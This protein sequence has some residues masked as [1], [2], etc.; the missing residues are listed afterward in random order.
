MNGQLHVVSVEAQRKWAI[1]KF[2]V[3]TWL[4]PCGS[5]AVLQAARSGDVLLFLQAVVCMCTFR[6][7]VKIHTLFWGGQATLQTSKQ[8]TQGNAPKAG[9]SMLMRLLDMNP[10]KGA[11]LGDYPCF[12]PHTTGLWGTLYAKVVFFLLGWSTWE[13]VAQHSMA[14]QGRQLDYVPQR[15]LSNARGQS[16]VSLLENVARVHFR[17][18]EH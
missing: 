12:H 10:S 6:P 16:S 17:H 15:S 3:P 2:S 13:G 11:S 5:F 9:N 8:L 14:M 18:L 1:F 7:D 4:A